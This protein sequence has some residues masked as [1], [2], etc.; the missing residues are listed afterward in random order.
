[1]DLN[2]SDRRAMHGSM[3]VDLDGIWLWLTIFTYFCG[4]SVIGNGGKI[5]GLS[6]TPRDC[7]LPGSSCRLW[8]VKVVWTVILHRIISQIE[9]FET[10]TNVKRR[11]ASYDMSQW[12]DFTRITIRKVKSNKLTAELFGVT[13]NINGGRWQRC[14]MRDF[15]N[16][17]GWYTHLRHRICVIIIRG[18][19]NRE[20]SV[21]GRGTLYI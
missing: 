19:G 4:V 7:G 18:V 5:N 8:E 9:K 6:P 13:G 20:V 21:I 16:N 2:W 10:W 3:Y 1:M 14:Q 11:G 17:I 12:L 15:I